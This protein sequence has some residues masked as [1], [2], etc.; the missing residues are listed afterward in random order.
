MSTQWL[1]RAVMM[2]IRTS[3]TGLV[4]CHWTRIRRKTTNVVVTNPS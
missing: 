1:W 2:E 3:E 4:P